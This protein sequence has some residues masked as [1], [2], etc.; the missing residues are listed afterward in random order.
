MVKTFIK[1]PVQVQAVKWTGYNI[2]EIQKFVG[3]QCT[4]VSNGSS[5]PHLIVYPLEGVLHAEIGDWI[6]RGV[7]GEI[8]P[9]KPDI[10]GQ[11]YEE[12]K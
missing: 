6:I 12:V 2:D 7:K 1:K 11:T 8:Y 10:F 4:F 9:C 3:N 5:N